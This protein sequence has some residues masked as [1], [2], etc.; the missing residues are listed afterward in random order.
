MLENKL[1]TSELDL[2][3]I[4]LIENYKKRYTYESPTLIVHIGKKT[5]APQPSRTE[6]PMPLIT[7][8]PRARCG[9]RT[10]A[11][12]ATRVRGLH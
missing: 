9:V 3:S 8:K 5:Q 10:H 2:P 7:R 4:A 1:Y 12:R 11:L 6:D